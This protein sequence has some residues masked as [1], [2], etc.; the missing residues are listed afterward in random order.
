MARLIDGYAEGLIDKAEFE[1]RITGLRQRI[2][3][4][5]EQA[6]TLR[7]EAALRA[8]LSLIVGRLE[9][10]AAAGARADGRRSTGRCSAT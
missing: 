1:P 5:E 6:T 8:T 4:W 9:D 7:D 2:K 10:F 3:S